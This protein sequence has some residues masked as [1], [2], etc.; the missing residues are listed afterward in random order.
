MPPPG[1]KWARFLVDFKEVQ[2]AFALAL[3]V[4]ASVLVARAAEDVGASDNVRLVEPKVVI[5]IE[6][7]EGQ[8][9]V[10]QV[11]Y[12][13]GVYDEQSTKAAVDKLASLVGAKAEKYQ[14]MPGATPEEVSKAFFVTQNIIDP[15]GGDVR[16]Q[17]VVRAF[18][19]GAKGKVDSFSVR[20][21]GMTPSPYSTLAAY[22]S[23][24]VALKGFYDAATKS[25][26]YRILVMADDPAEV[27]I[28]P[29]HVPDEMQTQPFE[30]PQPSRLPL[31]LGLIVLAGASA[32]A[33]VYFALL[34]KRS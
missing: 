3:A 31:L 8:G 26:E 9:D 28:P 16:L 7:V 4:L 17:P 11:H 21:M 10:V 12:T 5:A 33:L 14:Y 22:E 13:G 27:D 25:I 19:T 24:A 20:I 6:H 30:E 29:R 18:M 1:L 15:S 2:K 34:G 23:K 32:G